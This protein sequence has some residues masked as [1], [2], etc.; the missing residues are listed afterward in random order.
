MVFS[1][2]VFLF[3]FLPF[4]LICY[5]AAAATGR[6]WVKN[7]ALLF[8][9]ALFYAYGGIGCL[10]LLVFSVV[11]NWLVGLAVDK[12][13][14]NRRRRCF[15]AGL[16]FNLGILFLFKYLNMIGDTGAWIAGALSGSDVKSPIPHIVLP[17][18]ISF[19][20][21]QILSYQIDLYRGKV[22]CQRK[23]RDLALYVMLFPQLI[24]GPIVRYS[25]VQQ[26]IESRRTG[27]ADL[28]EGVFRFMT[29]FSKKVLLA[30][31]MGQAADLAFGL[32]NGRGL[33]PAWLGLFCYGFQLYL[34]F[35]AYSDMAIGLGRIFGFRFPENF[36]DPYLSKSIQEFWRRWHMTLSSWFR[37]YLY[38]PLGGSRKGLARTCVN[39]FIV[40]SLT[41]LWHGASWQYLLWG[42]YFA[43]FLIAERLWL[44]K[45]LQKLPCLVRR[46]YT[47]L[48]VAVGWVL[49]RAENLRLAAGYVRDMFSF[50]LLGTSTSRELAELAL[51]RKF[52]LLFVVSFLYCTPFFAAV[53]SKLEEKGL[54]AV[55]DAVVLVVF[56]LSVCEMMAGGYNP[57]IYFRF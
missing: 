54:G 40:F 22:P 26:E 14:G 19:Y 55:A 7:A 44:G 31:S 50:K 52:M 30:N 53:R 48:V 41:G 15:L 2:P 35:W 23:C 4:T 1:S 27:L 16:V 25:D 47:L 21:F 38:I 57:F 28:Y 56:F 20:T 49:F 6:V 17:I 13:P 9:S 18:G 33:L 51:D 45:I 32:E 39:I 29:G 3:L 43:V 36:D 42:I 37:D 24:A 5:L 34:D 8:C 10:C 46:L 12:S 11:V